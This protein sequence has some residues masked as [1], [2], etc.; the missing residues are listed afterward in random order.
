MTTQKYSR[1]ERFLHLSKRK[2]NQNKQQKT[3]HNLYQGMKNDMQN[4]AP[5]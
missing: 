3:G 1:C 2:K 4:R 5:A